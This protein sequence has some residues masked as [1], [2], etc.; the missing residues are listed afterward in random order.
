MI[1][2]M[3]GTATYRAGQGPPMVL[4]HGLADTWRTWEPV[5]PA[6]TEH[7]DVLA[8]TLPGHLR[9]LP[10][11]EGVQ[12]TAALV[13]DVVEADMVAAGIEKAPLVGNSLGGWLALELAVR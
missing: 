9:G 5:L 8:V 11:P 1:S 4:I 6:L 12:L 10:I 3:A 7:H 2:A 13:A